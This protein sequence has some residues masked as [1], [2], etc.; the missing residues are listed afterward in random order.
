MLYLPETA[1]LYV[2]LNCAQFDQEIYLEPELESYL[3]QTIMRYSTMA[4]IEEYSSSYQ[5]EELTKLDNSS[6]DDYL[7]E[8]ADYC[9]ICTGL[10]SDQFTT[11]K[12]DLKR[13][14]EVGQNA[15]HMLSN[16]VGNKNNIYRKLSNHFSDLIKILNHSQRIIADDNSINQPL[17]SNNDTKHKGYSKLSGVFTFNEMD[18]NIFKVGNIL[19]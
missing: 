19:H 14:Q 4:D 3:I 10:M 16:H 2:L 8:I 11:E 12:Q 13:L 18:P 5:I 9:L 17:L 1:H 15:F 7:K 6:H